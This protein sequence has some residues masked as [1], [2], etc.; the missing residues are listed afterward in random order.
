[1]DN[2]SNLSRIGEAA[3][4]ASSMVEEKKYW[5]EKFTGE[6][7]KTGFPYDTPAAGPGEKKMETME[8][9][10]P[11]SLFPGLM[12]LCNNSDSNLFM[13]MVTALTVLLYK[14]TGHQD[15]IVGMP[16][17]K[18]ETQGN[19]VN[20]A[21]ALRNRVDGTTTFK[22]LLLRVRQTIKEATANQDYPVEILAEQIEAP[23]AGDMFS[24]FDTAILLEN[25]QDKNYLSHLGLAMIFSC[26][27]SENSFCVEID[28]DPTLYYSETISNTGKR[29]MQLLTI[30]NNIDVPVSAVDI[31]PPEE[32]NLIKTFSSGPSVDFPYNRLVTELIDQHA[33]KDPTRTAIIYGNRRL[34]YGELEGQSNRLAAYL[35][36]NGLQT[37]DKVGIMMDRSIE[38]VTAVLAVWKAGG[39]YIPIDP[40]LPVKRIATIIDDAKAAVVLS[41]KKY[42]K[43][44]NSIQWECKSFKTFLC[45]D[46]EDILVEDEYEKSVLMD[47]K[48]WEF[49]GESAKD[50]IMGGGWISSYTGEHFGREVVE[51]FANNLFQK[52]QP[53]LHEKMKV[54]EIGCA[55][56]FSMFR[57]APL[58]GLYYGTDISR[59]IIEKNKARVE[60]EGI[61]NIALAA[62]PAHD[63]DKIEETDFDLI[64]INSVIQDFHGHNYLRKVIRKAVDK[65]GVKGYLFIGDVMDQDSKQA[66]I[67]DLTEFK[68]NNR[69]KHYK[70][71]IVWDAE[72]FISRS[73]FQDVVHDIPGIVA[74]DFSNKIYTHENELT[75]FRYD[76]MFRIDKQV[77]K[78]A[79]LPPRNKFQHDSR[80]LATHS[81]SN[82][83]SNTTPAN[84]AYVIYTSGSTGNPKGV[85]VEHIGMMNHLFAKIND[86]NI[87]SESIMSQTASFAFDISVWQFFA[88]LVTGGQTV[89]YSDEIILAPDRFI[90]RVVEDKITIL[91]IV[92]SYLSLLLEVLESKPA[93]LPSLEFLLVTGEAIHSRLV[94]RWFEKYPRIQMVNAYGPTEASDDI[95]HYFMDKAPELERIPIGKPIQ[96]F[97]IYIVDNDMIQV[98]VGVKGEICV[99]GIGVGRGYLGNETKTKEAFMTDPFLDNETRLYKTGDLGSWK[100][101][102]NIDFFGRKDYQVKI[103]GF[104]IELGE[105]ENKLTALHEV[106][107]AAVIDGGND[108]GDRYLCAYIVPDKHFTTPEF[109]VNE[110]KDFL[111]GQIPDYMIPQYFV[112]LEELPLSANGKV[113]RKKLPLP[114]IKKNADYVAP[115]NENEEKLVA[116]LADILTLNKESIGIDDNLFDLGANSIKILSIQNRVSQVFGFEI[117]LSLFFLYPTVRELAVSIFEEQT[118]NGL[119]CVIKLNKGKNK[120]NLFLI[121]ALHGMVYHYKPMAD[122]LS[123]HFNIY[124]VQSRGV[125]STN[126]VPLELDV[127]IDDYLAQIKAVQPEGPYILGG[128]CVG[129]LIGYEMVKALERI[130]DEVLL[131]ILFDHPPMMPLDVLTELR[132]K[133]KLEQENASEAKVVETKV[134]GTKYKPVI[135]SISKSSHQPETVFEKATDSFMKGEVQIDY[136]IPLVQDKRFEMEARIAQV[137]FDITGIVNTDLLIIEPS[138]TQLKRLDLEHYK[139]ATYK[140]AVIEYCG[141]THN[142][143]FNPPHVQGLSEIV[144]KYALKALENRK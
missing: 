139:Q 101:D 84:L 87:N 96:N 109:D 39:A 105:I 112:K 97:K 60:R 74:V 5:M 49:I 42:I 93:H 46:S 69:E 118:L 126:E 1:M 57:I 103:R 71:K 18:Q 85:L 91:E 10:L 123:D 11:E 61:Q 128:F 110:L 134:F 72:L 44:L 141:G 36:E 9:Q 138:E 66:L 108:E 127:M 65:L 79:N 133:E 12:K 38:T 16:I 98:P 111:E 136:I 43:T 137:K 31:I 140:S 50:D 33:K 59:V 80:A 25:I 83:V 129:T 88:A 113:D 63:I 48:L 54:L 52:L 107:E 132:E 95:T 142:S 135:E 26:K 58:V 45:I 56:G 8:F 92:P 27:K 24:L 77:E 89:V 2:K 104:R 119:E 124:G 34:T 30:V 121:H 143:V 94:N 64:I 78:P 114:N 32:K 21:L 7:V 41:E 102:G 14:H 73:F 51:E 23:C 100:P 117:S 120:P 47:P 70:T 15:I 67:D 82:F 75:K 22:E 53:V 122:L 144:L 99:S 13:I 115:S 3:V 125:C 29:L 19:L 68:R 55:S 4:A 40:G 35:V 86:L 76:T 28:Y 17:F 37:E 116:I 20:T 81:P 90:S 106:K 6:W 62:M 130:N 131:F